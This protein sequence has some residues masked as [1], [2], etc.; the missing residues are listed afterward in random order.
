[1]RSS[2]AHWG[3]L[4]ASSEQSKAANAWLKTSPGRRWWREE[5]SSDSTSTCR[6]RGFAHER[7]PRSSAL[8]GHLDVGLVPALRSAVI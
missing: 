2:P 1:M 7:Q 3:E 4:V 6:R 5:P 8:D